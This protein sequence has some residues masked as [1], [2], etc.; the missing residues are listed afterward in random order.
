MPISVVCSGCSAK[1]SAPDTA[2][3]KR[4]KCPKRQGAIAVPAPAPAEVAGAE[5]VKKTTRPAVERDPD[6]KPDRE[7]PRKRP[8]ADEDDKPHR[9]RSRTDEPEGRASKAPIVV[10]AV[11]AGLVAVIGVVAG[12]YFFKADRTNTT[13]NNGPP[14]QGLFPNP[15]TNLPNQLPRFRDVHSVAL[16]RDGKLIAVSGFVPLSDSRNTESGAWVWDFRGQPTEFAPPADSQVEPLALSPDGT[17]LATRPLRTGSI[18]FRSLKTK[19]IVKTVAPP[20]NTPPLGTMTFTDDGA[21]V[22]LISE[23]TAVGVR[24]DGT[25]TE[26][27]NLRSQESE[28]AMDHCMLYV[29]GL[30]RIATLRGVDN[31]SGPELAL[32]DPLTTDPPTTVRLK[33]VNHFA[34]SYT[35]SADGSTVAVC[36][37]GGPPE[38][39]IC[40]LTFHSAQD[41]TRTGLLPIKAGPASGYPRL[42]LSPDGQYLAGVTP[43]GAYCDLIRVTDGKR[44]HRAGNPTEMDLGAIGKAG[45]MFSNNGKWLYFVVKEELR[46]VATDSGE[47]VPLS[48]AP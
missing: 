42:V 21:A 28:R 4:V 5:P 29:P 46:R 14:E 8:A 6:P 2:T 36:A 19:Q 20:I 32:W 3:G 30:K 24:L 34:G 45:P 7:K 26:R 40:E 27:T 9:N 16:S 38:K 12:V 31:P 13:S 41:G 25:V 23:D 11:L 10:G 39:P 37:R 18:E 22:V 43:A 48:A 15:P 44:L 1:L 33:G 35:V 47:E 17:M